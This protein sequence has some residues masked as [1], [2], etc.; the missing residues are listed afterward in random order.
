MAHT[1]AG[2]VRGAK[3]AQQEMLAPVTRNMLIQPCV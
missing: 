3:G 1:Q 2:G